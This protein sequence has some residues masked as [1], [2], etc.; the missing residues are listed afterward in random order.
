MQRLTITLV[1]YKWQIKFPPL[2]TYQNW[3]LT[4]NE[5]AAHIIISNKWQIKR[6]KNLQKTFIKMHR[7]T[8]ICSKENNSYC[9]VVATLLNAG[10]LPMATYNKCNHEIW[11]L[12]L[13]GRIGR[14][15]S[16]NLLFFLLKVCSS[17][18]SCSA[19]HR[20]GR[21][22]CSEERKTESTRQLVLNLYL[23]A[24]QT[25]IQQL[26]RG[27]TD[28]HEAQIS[29]YYMTVLLEMLYKLSISYKSIQYG[30]R[31]GGPHISREVQLFQRISV[32]LVRES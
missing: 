27:R 26:Q 8:N 14:G 29:M 2:P 13:K 23:P 15:Y 5:S 31:T 16:F 30:C 7:Q 11:M 18:E 24:I 17:E 19:N 9:L 3:W 4:P 1:Q 32:I 25:T 20:E 28:L 12:G 6:D 21:S 10:W 22:L